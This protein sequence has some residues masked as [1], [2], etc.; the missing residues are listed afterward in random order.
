M[1]RAQELYERWLDDPA[2]DE[3]TRAE[4]LAIRG[5]TAEIEDR[6][7]MDLAFGTAGLR[8][9][10]GAG[11]NRMNR[12]TVARAAAGFAS[13]LA[14]FGEERRQRGIVIS[15]DSRH[16]SREFAWQTARIFVGYDVRVRIVDEMR[17]VPML[18][19]AIRH[20]Q[21]AGGVMITASHNPAKYNGFKAYGD[22][23]AQLPPDAADVVSSS[24]DQITDLARIT[25]PDEPTARATG[26]LSEIGPELDQA[27]TAMLLDLSIAG[28]AVSRHKGLKIVYTPLH[29]TGYKPVTRILRAV[30]FENIL[31]VP[32]QAIPDPDFSTVAFPNPEERS[33]LTMAINLAEK[34]GADLVIATDPDAD[35]TGLCVRTRQGDYVVLSGNQIGQL[36]LE[37]ILSSRQAAGTLPT[38]SFAITTI[39]SSK[40]TRRIAAAYGVTLFECLTGFKFIAE[41]IKEHDEQGS[42]H[43]Q[44]GFEESF[45]YLAGRDVRDKDAV[46]TS[47]LIAEMAAAASD[48]GQTLY[49]RLQA[50]YE[51][52][53]FAAEY[54]IAITLEGKEGIER[55]KAAM[56]ALRRSKAGGFAAEPVLAVN[57]YLELERL[58]L[59]SGQ[60]APLNLDRS[61]VLLY[62]LSGID[63]FCV[64]PSGTEPKL[65]IYFGIYRS[66]REAGEQELAALR[67]RVEAAVR[68]LL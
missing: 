36:L 27:Y 30:G 3:A 22:D 31:V 10:L 50:L 40:L 13:Y 12:Y 26:L 68:A 33:A 34:E 23:G 44:F 63:W 66:S 2:F 46:V 4:L 37:F 11:T 56:A 14:G 32:E 43:F 49:D 9:I 35:R 42:M 67:G 29:G 59:A 20:F 25:W 28:D 65:K 48:M 7:Y 15:Y 19:F 8:G 55:I 52:Y 45:G 57:D 58:D 5:D 21:A 24:M 64:R 6:F 39:V 60:V 41:L 1:T 16:F 62:E 18:S 38:N 53:G 47:M 51:R 54:T 17:P 61:D